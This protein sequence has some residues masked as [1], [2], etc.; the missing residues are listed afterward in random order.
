MAKIETYLKRFRGAKVGIFRVT[1]KKSDG[2]LR[3]DAKNRRRIIRL[4][5]H[6]LYLK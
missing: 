5:E 1:C 4:S 6:Y 3:A 2:Y